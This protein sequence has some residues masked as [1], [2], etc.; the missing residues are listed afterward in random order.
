[1][2]VAPYST[3]MKREIADII[4]RNQLLPLHYRLTVTVLF[5]FV[6]YRYSHNISQTGPVSVV[7]QVPYRTQNNILPEKLI[8][9]NNIDLNLN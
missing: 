2:V 5:E 7:V 1:M 9:P 8:Q 6:Q 4:L 3:V